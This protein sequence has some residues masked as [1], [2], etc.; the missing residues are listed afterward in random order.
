MLALGHRTL[1]TGDEVALVACPLAPLCFAGVETVSERVHVVLRFKD[2]D[3]APAE[4]RQLPVGAPRRLI[5]VAE[6]LIAIARRGQ[7][8]DGEDL[9]GLRPPVR[10][11]L[12][13]LLLCVRIALADLCRVEEVL[14]EMRLDEPQRALEGVQIVISEGVRDYLE[15]Q[16]PRMPVPERDAQRLLA[17]VRSRLTVARRLVHS[18][19]NLAPFL[20]WI[21]PPRDSVLEAGD[22]HA[23]LAVHS[24]Q[25]P[26]G[27][28]RVGTFLVISPSGVEELRRGAAIHHEHP[29]DPHL[30]ALE[31][32]M[33]F[34]LEVGPRIV[35]NVDVVA[36]D[37]PHAPDLVLEAVPA[38]P[39]LPAVADGEVDARLL[40]HWLQQ[41]LHLPLIAV[42]VAVVVPSGNRAPHRSDDELVA[43][44][45]RARYLL[46][47]ELHAGFIDLIS[48]PQEQRVRQYIRPFPIVL[49]HLDDAVHLV[50]EPVDVKV[51]KH[52]VRVLLS[53]FGVP[54]MLVELLLEPEIGQL[55]LELLDLVPELVRWVVTP[56]LV[57]PDHLLLQCPDELGFF[58]Q[59]LLLLERALLELRL[60]SLNLCQPCVHLRGH[61]IVFVLELIQFK[62]G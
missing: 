27:I 49:Q 56:L 20:P 22:V 34:V 52:L 45:Q 30:V 14:V 51:E 40:E 61:L 39:P 43:P 60:P 10:E 13:Y 38:R 6:F 24:L 35:R 11:Q 4:R 44:D 26:G 25:V 28:E 50:G 17:R 19:A 46:G 33:G 58:L 2:P 37:V 12:S 54:G 53:A 57:H 42:K 21:A 15:S 59:R 32:L 18:V 47:H 8:V 48:R 36:E 3:L 55:L 41:A 16:R 9:R 1:V 62:P 23:E 31:D 29:A 7:L 5:D